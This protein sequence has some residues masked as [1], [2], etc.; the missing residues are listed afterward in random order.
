MESPKVM[1]LMGIHD[2]DA[3]QCYAGYTYCP[4]CGK[5]GQNE[6]TMVNHLRMTYYRLGLVC[7]WCFGMGIKTVRNI[8]S[9]LDQVCPIDL[10]ARLGIFIREQSQC[11]TT[12][13]PSPWK[14]RFDKEGTA[15]QSAK[16]IFC[17]HPAS[18]TNSYFYVS[19]DQDRLRKMLLITA[20]AVFIKVHQ[21]NN[22]KQLDK[23]V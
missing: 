6:V 23:C 12:G 8:V 20:K 15:H 7:D 18:P 22:S 4:W 19:C 13:P 9:P 16:S 5:E 2:P 10:L 14:A 3:L 21:N 11:Y 1:G 17:Y